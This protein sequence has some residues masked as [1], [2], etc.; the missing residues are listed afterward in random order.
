[1]MGPGG[2][3]PGGPQ[4][5]PRRGTPKVVPVVVSAGLA[6]GVFCGLLFGLGTGSEEATASTSPSNGKPKEAAVSEVAE[7]FRPKEVPDAPRAP[8]LNLG[9]AAAAAAGSA[10]VAGLGS[11]SAAPAAGSAAPTAVSNKA[12]LTIVV[13]PEAAAV[14]AKLSI[15]GGEVSPTSEVD[16]GDRK[17]KR[18]AVTVKA[19]G[20]QDATKEI[21]LGAGSEVSIELDLIRK[22]RVGPPLPPRPP[23]GGG[24][25]R[26]PPSRPSGGGLIDI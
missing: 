1:M 26:P 9:S 21:D 5:G 15:N 6:V 2:M 18:V 16:L 11:G 12:K 8:K 20:Y 4:G 24:V 3:R 14:V 7:P 10:A 25:R 22:P 13:R 17:T 19:V 23:T